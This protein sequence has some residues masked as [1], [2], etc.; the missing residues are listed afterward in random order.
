MQLLRVMAVSEKQ[1]AKNERPYFTCR[2]KPLVFLPNGKEVFSSQSE[3]TRTIWGAFEDEQGN[4][5]KADTLYNDLL[6]G[7]LTPS[8]GVTGVITTF[9]TTPYQVGNNEVTTT[10]V[11]SFENENPETVA[12]AQLKQH[13]ACVVINGLLTKESNLTA[14]KTSSVVK[15][16][17]I[18]A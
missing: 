2:F 9:N 13:N 18:E 10:T 16:E 7:N 3:R 4:K 6:S 15:M 12:N 1:T 11:V 14:V 8:A 5:Y 17:E